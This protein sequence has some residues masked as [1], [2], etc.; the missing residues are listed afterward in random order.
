[1]DTGLRKL[2][3]DAKRQFVNTMRD[4]SFIVDDS[5]SVGI[6]TVLDPA[7]K[8]HM[9]VGMLRIGDSFLK[10]DVEGLCDAI[11]AELRQEA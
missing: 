1:M 7:S 4:R 2:G 6:I 3:I 10:N 8:R 9:S 11:Q 5:S